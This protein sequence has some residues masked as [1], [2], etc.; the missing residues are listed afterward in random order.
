MPPKP[1]FR[2]FIAEAKRKHQERKIADE[3]QRKSK[4]AGTTDGERIDAGI[5]WL[6]VAVLPLLQEARAVLAGEKIELAVH[7][8]FDVHG[9]PHLPDVLFQCLGPAS[10]ARRGLRRRSHSDKY[11]IRC[12]GEGFEV[13]IGGDPASAPQRLNP[14]V[15][16][17]DKRVDDR[18]NDAICACIQSYYDSLDSGG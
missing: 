13:G 16:L 15:K 5:R 11:W 18:L 14:K 9:T 4:S 10:A 1:D 3:R 2:A 8:S 6:K 7:P 17:T 12:D